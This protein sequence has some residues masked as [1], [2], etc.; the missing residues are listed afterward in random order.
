[1]IWMSK[2]QGDITPKEFLVFFIWL[3]VVLFIGGVQYYRIVH[4]LGEG[5][6]IRVYREIIVGLIALAG[7]TYAVIIRHRD[8]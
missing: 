1:M 4:F 6:M 2:Q 7:L 5:S 3:L 8:L